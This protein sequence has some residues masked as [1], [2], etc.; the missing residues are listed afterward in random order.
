[1]IEGDLIAFLRDRLGVPVS[2][3][4]PAVRPARF[5]TVSRTG[6][7]A[8]SFRDF[9]EFAVQAW[10]SS[11]S[12][13]AALAVAARRELPAMIEL[14]HVGRVDLRGLYEYPDADSG[15]SRYQLVVGLTVST[16]L[17]A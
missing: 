15:Q 2:A 12:D 6:G 16:D 13:A 4:V 9:P 11:P 8:D 10:G 7:G 5:V 14:P 1:M 17:S 3:S